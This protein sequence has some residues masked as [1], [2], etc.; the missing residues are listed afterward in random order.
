MLMVKPGLPYL[1]IL[2]RVRRK[3]NVPLA[4]YHV[5]GEYSMIKAAAQKGWIDEKAVVLEALKGFRRAG[6]D[7]IA[8]YYA[9]D[10]AKWMA[11]DCSGSRSFTEPC[12]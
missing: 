4:A 12:F 2:H 11:N 7:A 8:T 5:S 1:D 6:A 3:V 9:K 10:A